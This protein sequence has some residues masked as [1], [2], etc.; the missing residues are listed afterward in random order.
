[1]PTVRHAAP[2]RDA[3]DSAAAS[4]WRAATAIGTSNARAAVWHARAAVWRADA[5]DSDRRDAAG[6]RRAAARGAN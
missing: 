5:A 3:G 1:M 4:V 6:E 2:D